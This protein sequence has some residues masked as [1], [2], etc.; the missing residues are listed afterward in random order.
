MIAIAIIGPQMHTQTI[1]K[2]QEIA[3][4]HLQP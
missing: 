1:W 3:A 4:Q 2:P